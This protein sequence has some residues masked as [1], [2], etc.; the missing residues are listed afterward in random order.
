MRKISEPWRLWRLCRG[1]IVV[2]NQVVDTVEG[3]K[4][5]K[6]IYIWLV[7]NFVMSQ[8]CVYTE[9]SMQVMRINSILYVKC[10]KASHANRESG[11]HHTSIQKILFPSAKYASSPFHSHR[12]TSRRHRQ[13]LNAGTFNYRPTPSCPMYSFFLSDP[14]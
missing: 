14:H 8:H 10:K 7:G 6:G 4:C 12:K 1:N 9:N 3:E 13:D 2:D 11:Y 5:K